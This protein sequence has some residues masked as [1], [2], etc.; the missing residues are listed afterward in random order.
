MNSKKIELQ[1]CPVINPKKIKASW[2]NEGDESLWVELLDT[3]QTM[4]PKMTK[5]MVGYWRGL[6]KK[7]FFGNKTIIDY[8]DLPDV[9][10]FI[11][12]KWDST[13]K[14]KVISYI[15]DKGKIVNRCMGWSDCRICGIRNG[16]NCC[17]D[18][19]WV[20]P[21]GFVHYLEIHNVKPPQEFIDYVIKKKI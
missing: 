1:S 6:P 16:S 11:D 7:S 4:D 20:W 8:P 9:N 17:G 19:K 5:F 18:G 12:P 10:D 14:E 13:E 3:P 2:T 21:E 15:L